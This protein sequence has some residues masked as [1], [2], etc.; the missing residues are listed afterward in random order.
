MLVWLN[1]NYTFGFRKTYGPNSMLK[2][3]VKASASTIS[4]SRCWLAQLAGAN[5]KKRASNARNVLAHGIRS[6]GSECKAKSTAKRR[7]HDPLG[8]ARIGNLGCN[9]SGRR[10]RDRRT[11]QMSDQ[12]LAQSLLTYLREQG[13]TLE[14][15]IELLCI[16]VT[17]R[18]S[19]N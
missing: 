12:I 17:Y 4:S 6:E 8:A 18:R 10:P 1:H 13:L 11:D 7:H 5:H 15:A 19:I 14:P 3:N 9:H 16:V 2:P